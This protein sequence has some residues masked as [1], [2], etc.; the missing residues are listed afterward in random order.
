[1]KLKTRLL[2]LA[3][4]GLG[5]FL[6]VLATIFTM[7]LITEGT[8][9]M[10][11]I[12]WLFF[13]AVGLTAFFG[14]WTLFYLY[15]IVDLIAKNNSFSERTLVLVAKVKHQILA[16]AIS[17][18]GILPFVAQVADLEDAP[19]LILV[20]MGPILLPFAAYLFSL[21]VEEL[22][23]NAISLKNEQDLTI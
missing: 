13:A 17:F 8:T 12:A 21:I 9:G 2:K 3:L 5:A 19:G 10:S 15:Q 11:A 14:L 4:V 18:C 20:G 1:M 7:S 16:A 6:L 23:K 22:F